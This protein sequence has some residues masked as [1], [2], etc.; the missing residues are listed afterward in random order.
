MPLAQPFGE[1]TWCQWAL[2]ARPPH[3]DRQVLGFHWGGGGRSTKPC[4]VNFYL[5]VAS[6][7]HPN[8]PCRFA[9]GTV[10]ASLPQL[11]D[12]V[13][14]TVAAGTYNSTSCGSTT[15][16]SLALRG[17]GSATTII[18]C[19]GLSR[20]LL[21]TGASYVGGAGMWGDVVCPVTHRA[22][23]VALGEGCCASRA[24]CREVQGHW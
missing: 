20:M 18:D 23:D 8:H 10:V 21:S 14:V 12:A 1:S 11:A 2:L 3:G 17:A 15:N 5:R 16:R 6:S 19:G 24:M 7:V 22:S 9:I 4:H 13:I